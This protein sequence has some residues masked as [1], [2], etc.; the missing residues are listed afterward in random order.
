M[1]PVTR[2]APRRSRGADDGAICS[3]SHLLVPNRAPLAGRGLSS[4]HEATL[5][6]VARGAF[7]RPGDLL[8]AAGHFLSPPV[9]RLR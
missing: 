5:D 1:F 6:E 2:I 8:I 9:Q 3:R 4:T 7:T